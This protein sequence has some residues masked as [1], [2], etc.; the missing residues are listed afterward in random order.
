MTS[1]IIPCNLKYY[2]VEGAFNNLKIIDWK[3]SATKIEV[4]DDVY[5]YVSSPVRAIKYQCIVKKVLMDHIE[6][7]DSPYVL[8]GTNYLS[9]RYH[10]QLELVRKF[11]DELKIDELMKHGL[12]SNIQSP[13][14]VN[15]ELEN[16]FATV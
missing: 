15:N 2:D 1:W 10:M 5:I 4:G 7:D 9:S 11:N 3:Q 8:D 14:R 13:R 16:F 12:T 6:I